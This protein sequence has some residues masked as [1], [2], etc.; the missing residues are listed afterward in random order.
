MAIVEAE[1][2]AVASSRMSYCDVMGDGKAA[3]WLQ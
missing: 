2:A 1:Q 3:G